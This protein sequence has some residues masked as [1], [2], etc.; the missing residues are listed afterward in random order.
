MEEQN[1][2]SDPEVKEII[3]PTPV[4][5][6]PKLSKI[7]VLILV[8]CGVLV[9][10]SFAAAYFLGKNSSDEQVACTQEAKIC[11]DGSAVG[12]TG[13]KCEFAPCPTGGDQT[14]NP[15]L[16]PGEPKTNETANW[17]TYTNSYFSFKHPAVWETGDISSNPNSGLNSS[18]SLFLLPRTEGIEIPIV[19]SN[20]YNKSVVSQ[21][22]IQ[23]NKDDIDKL[24]ILKVGGK[25][26]IVGTMYTR[27]Q[28]ITVDGLA[29]QVYDGTAVPNYPAEIMPY[30]KRVILVK[31]NLIYNFAS[32]PSSGDKNDPNVETFNKLLT[33]IKLY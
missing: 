6:K 31:N 26:Q 14:G 10:A 19:I 22:Y 33:T 25:K 12:R 17:Q 3:P 13:P 2:D 29:A 20:T 18:V 28:D 24:L 7:K 11:P 30:E 32:A 15:N 21:D 27:I 8:A 16:D 1:K 4:P 9:L 23:Q 5:D